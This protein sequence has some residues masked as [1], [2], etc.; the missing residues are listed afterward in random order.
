MQQQT[1]LNPCVDIVENSTDCEDKEKHH[2]KRKL[3]TSR[4]EEMTGIENMIYFTCHC[5]QQHILPS[6]YYWYLPKL[7]FLH[8]QITNT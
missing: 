4:K 3:D 1:G 8:N 7:S 5:H 6:N 2:K